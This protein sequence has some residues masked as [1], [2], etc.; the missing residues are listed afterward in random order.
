VDVATKACTIDAPELDLKTLCGEILY[1]TAM[2][3]LLYLFELVYSN[4]TNPFL[5]SCVI[6]SYAAL[7]AISWRMTSAIRDN[8][9]TALDFWVFSFFFVVFALCFFMIGP[10]SF[11]QLGTIFQLL[12]PL[13]Y[14]ALI[15][16]DVIAITRHPEFSF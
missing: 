4:L 16:A 10:T 8:T 3:L 7:V 15:C 12:Y 6:P 2:A 11:N 1:L 9:E 13:P 14:L 5:L